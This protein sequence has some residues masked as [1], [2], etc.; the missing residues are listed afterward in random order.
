M[1]ESSEQRMTAQHVES[2]RNADKRSKQTQ[3]C[4]RFLLVQPQSENGAKEERKPCEGGRGRRNEQ[5]CK[6]GFDLIL[7]R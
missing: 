3:P 5:R 6:R 7:L 2:G 1:G 4:C